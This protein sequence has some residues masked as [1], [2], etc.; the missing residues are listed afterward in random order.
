V[1]STSPVAGARFRHHL[2]MDDVV[3]LRAGCPTARRSSFWGTRPNAIWVRHSGHSRSGFGHLRRLNRRSAA[4]NDRWCDWARMFD[5]ALFLAIAPASI[6]VYLDVVPEPDGGRDTVFAARAAVCAAESE[7]CRPSPT[8]LFSTRGTGM[9]EGRGCPRGRGTDP[10]RSSLIGWPSID[11]R[12]P[13]SDAR[14]PTP[15][16]G[17]GRTYNLPPVHIREPDMRQRAGAPDRP[18]NAL[19]PDPHRRRHPP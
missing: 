3:A 18:G 9:F 1:S 5:E 16:C 2:H 15:D 7:Q 10:G 17:F 6:T 14:P 11:G 13:S 8:P 4:R 19:D 12:G